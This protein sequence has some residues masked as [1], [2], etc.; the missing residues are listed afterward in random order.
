LVVLIVTS[1]ASVVPVCFDLCFQLD[2]NI[3]LLSHRQCAAAKNNIHA[4]SPLP[5]YTVL[6][7]LSHMQ[8]QPPIPSWTRT[9]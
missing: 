9:D 7:V 8:T 3:D 2:T 5:A 6:C 4:L 1:T